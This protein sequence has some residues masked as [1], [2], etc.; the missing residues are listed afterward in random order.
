MSRQMSP[1]RQREFEEL[2]SYLE[3]VTPYIF[4]H[5]ASNSP[6]LAA[7]LEEIVTKFGKSKALVGLRQ[8]I[9]DTVEATSHYTE[10]QITELDALLSEKGVSTLSQIRH[11]YS[12]SYKRI[13][14]RGEIKSDTEYYLMNGILLDQG[15]Q[16]GEAERASLENMVACYEA[17]A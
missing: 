4:P 1:E 6:S 10:K 15:L 7:A 8:A 5:R 9:N 14:K 12:A 16:I 3:C 13:L 2:R 17:N 11:R